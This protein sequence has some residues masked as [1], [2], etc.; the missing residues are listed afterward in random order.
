VL[1]SNLSALAHFSK[2]SNIRGLREDFEFLHEEAVVG[3]IR[4]ELNS[5]S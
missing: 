5:P 4:L 1:R 2:L 3:T